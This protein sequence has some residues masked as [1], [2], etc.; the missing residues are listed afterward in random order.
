MKKND[1]WIVYILLVFLVVLDLVLS[2][3]G[4][5]F[6]EVWFRFWHNAPYEDPQALLPRCA[7]NWFAFF[8]FQLIA[9][10]MW[11]KAPWWLAVVAG[12]RFSDIFTDLTV[13]LLGSNIAPHTMI[14]FPMMG[15]A[16]FLVAVLLIRYY[17]KLTRGPAA[18]EH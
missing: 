3:W 14:L 2:L 17:L 13:T 4:F 5:F 8:L 1:E 15:V 16:N 12:M 18:P 11:K 7:A 10:F 6:P 9:L